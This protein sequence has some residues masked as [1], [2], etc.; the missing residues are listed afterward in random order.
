MPSVII[1]S[2]SLYT[3]PA[4]YSAQKTIS[5][6]T[7]EAAEAFAEAVNNSDQGSSPN[8]TVKAIV[9]DSTEQ[10]VNGDIPH[11]LHAL[12]VDRSSRNIKFESVE[13]YT[14]TNFEYQRF[15]GVNPAIIHAFDN[16][17]IIAPATL[18]ETEQRFHYL[19]AG[20]QETI[21]VYLS[22]LPDIRERV[23]NLLASTININS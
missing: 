21:D 22:F 13:V 6:Y 20:D 4:T 14:H 18:T 12:Y 1:E 16:P 8:N 5:F 23:Q 2:K 9:V 11:L 19:A 3:D 7:K 15:F 17:D 10:A